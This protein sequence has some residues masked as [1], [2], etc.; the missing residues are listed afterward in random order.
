MGSPRTSTW[1]QRATPLST[2]ALGR[3]KSPS[4]ASTLPLFVNPTSSACSVLTTSLP[5]LTHV[6]ILF[7]SWCPQ[8]SSLASG[9]TLTACVARLPRRLQKMMLRV[10]RPSTPLYTS[11]RSPARSPNDA[12]PPLH[13]LCRSATIYRA[14]RHRGIEWHGVPSA[15]TRR[16]RCSRASL[17]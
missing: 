11:T 15:V 2:L 12:H 17:G 5:P 14:P 4:R 3:L 6:P 8:S 10:I 1:M 9:P 16:I 13:I 7:G